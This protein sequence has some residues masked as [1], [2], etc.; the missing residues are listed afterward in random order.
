MDKL[1]EEDIPGLL[2]SVGFEKASVTVEWPFIG[3]K[4][5]V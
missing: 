4:P 1:E 2:M 3:K 5:L